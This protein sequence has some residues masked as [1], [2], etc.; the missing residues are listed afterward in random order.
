MK[1]K[2]DELKELAIVQA[3]LIRDA[4]RES[5]TETAAYL[6]ATNPRLVQLIRSMSTLQLMQLVKMTSGV[7]LMR[8]NETTATESVARSIQQD[9]GDAESAAVALLVEGHAE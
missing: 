2:L 5:P 6:G 3:L 8:L 7:G 4:L 9:T 1:T